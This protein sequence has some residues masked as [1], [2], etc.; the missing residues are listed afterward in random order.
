LD[1]PDAKEPFNAPNGYKVLSPYVLVKIQYSTREPER[2]K[3]ER[4]EGQTS[5]PICEKGYWDTVEQRCIE[6]EIFHC[7]ITFRI[8]TETHR[9][10]ISSTWKENHAQYLGCIASTRG[11]RVG[12]DWTRDSDLPDG[13]F[14]R[15]TWERIKN[16]IFR[17]EMKAVSKYIVNGR[18]T[19]YMEE[20]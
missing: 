17:Y 5:E 2:P 11:F 1:K 8:Y 19:G 6:E 10:S 12:E 9:Y 15:E 14:C 13:Y 7:V 20:S 16:A 4:E 3:A 18:Y